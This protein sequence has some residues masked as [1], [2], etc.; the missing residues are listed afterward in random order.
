[1]VRKIKLVGS[2]CVVVSSCL[3]RFHVKQYEPFFRVKKDTDRPFLLHHSC[4]AI[5]LCRK[6]MQA[7]VLQC[8][9]EIASQQSVLQKLAK[10]RELQ[11]NSGDFW[12]K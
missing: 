7:E 10:W 12:R 11:H 4:G 2:G 9:G 6:K 1:V 5:S 3:R 8:G